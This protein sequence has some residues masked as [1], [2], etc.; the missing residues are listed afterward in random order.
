MHRTII[1]LIDVQYVLILCLS[2][3]SAWYGRSHLPLCVDDDETLIGDDNN[4][5]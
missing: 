4:E 5:N 1:L 3:A 2:L